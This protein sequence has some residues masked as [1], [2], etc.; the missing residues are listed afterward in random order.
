MSIEPIKEKQH[1]IEHNDFLKFKEYERKCLEEANL[2]EKINELRHQEKTCKRNYLDAKKDLDHVTH[3]LRKDALKIRNDVFGDSPIM[4]VLNFEDFNIRRDWGSKNYN[5]SY[6]SD[7]MSLGFVD[8]IHYLQGNRNFEVMD[9]K[10][11]EYEKNSKDLKQLVD[12]NGE[13]LAISSLDKKS[14]DII[15]HVQNNYNTRIEKMT[16]LNDIVEPKNEYTIHDLNNEYT[17]HDL[18]NELKS[19]KLWLYWSCVIGTI[20]VSSLI[21][22]IL[23]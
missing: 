14:R 6:L 22:K 13:K 7:K 18:K 5:R 15:N 17:I 20:L 2:E 4:G 16:T 9:I 11:F 12:E 23:G 10:L 3:N 8:M 1:I 21:F 19:T